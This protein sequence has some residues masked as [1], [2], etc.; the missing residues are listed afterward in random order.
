VPPW[1]YSA[2]YKWVSYGDIKRITNKYIKFLRLKYLV[3][4]MREKM[5][6]K[7]ESCEDTKEEK[8]TDVWR[9]KAKDEIERLGRENSDTAR[10]K[11]RDMRR[12]IIQTNYKKETCFPKTVIFT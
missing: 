4:E 9:N 1:N 10:K 7:R 3:N 12:K 6:E 5:R 8:E 2:L 11:R